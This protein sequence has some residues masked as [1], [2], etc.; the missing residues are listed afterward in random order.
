MKKLIANIVTAFLIGMSIGSVSMQA[1]AEEQK[2]VQIDVSKLTDEQKA[3]INAITTS[4]QKKDDVKKDT[5]ISISPSTLKNWGDNL[6]SAAEGFARAI[7]IAAH[8][9]N[10]EVNNF[11]SS[12]VGMLT[13]GI[14]LMKLFGSSLF[15]IIFTLIGMFVLIRTCDALI[16]YASYEKVTTKIQKKAILWGLIPEREV[17]KTSFNRKSTDYISEFEGFL[18]IVGYVVKFTALIIFVVNVK[19]MF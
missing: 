7:G 12:P 3:Q 13:I 18:T 10:I 11:A 15:G 17:I 2:V 4:P 8:E 9:L 14:V 5:A 19:S 1:H 16:K 6:A